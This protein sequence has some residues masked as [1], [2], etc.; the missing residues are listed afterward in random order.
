MADPTVT[1][2]TSGSSATATTTVSFSAQ[3]AGTLLVLIYGG[4]DYRTTSGSGRPES[5]GWTLISDQHTFL[6]HAAWYKIAAG[7]ETS[8]QYTIG[9]ASPSCY[10]LITATNIDGTTPVDIS[11]GQLAQSSLN[12]YTT[13][14]VTTTAGRRLGIAAMGATSVIIGR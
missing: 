3:T 2:L 5:T 6:G 1:L 4:D 13:P 12:N 8:V 10:Q 14:S 11:N 7:S 9:S